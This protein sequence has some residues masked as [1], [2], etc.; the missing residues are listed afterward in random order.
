[1]AVSLKTQAVQSIWTISVIWHKVNTNPLVGLAYLFG[2]N[3][4]Q[5]VDCITINVVTN[6]LCTVEK[7]TQYC[8]VAFQLREQFAVKKLLKIV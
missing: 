5:W 7:S 6:S 2:Y 1:M 8:M 3:D 4:I